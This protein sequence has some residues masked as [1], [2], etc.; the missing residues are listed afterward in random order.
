[1]WACGAVLGAAAVGSEISPLDRGNSS[2]LWL[3]GAGMLLSLATLT[4]VWA[5]QRR[6]QSGPEAPAA[7]EPALGPGLAFDEPRS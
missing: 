3:F 5:R 1:V 2:T 7:R 4:L 6:T